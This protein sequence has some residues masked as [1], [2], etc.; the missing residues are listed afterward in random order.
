MTRPSVSPRSRRSRSP[1]WYKDAAFCEHGGAL[2]AETG[3]FIIS[4]DQYDDELP[5]WTQVAGRDQLIIPYYALTGNDMRL[6]AA[7]L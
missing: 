6:H 7:G 2:A 1:R 4:S 5:Y 3:E